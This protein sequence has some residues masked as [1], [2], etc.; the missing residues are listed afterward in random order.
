L[1]DRRALTPEIVNSLVSPDIGEKWIGDA[2]LQG[3]GVRLWAS[4]NGDGVRFAIR[5]RDDKGVVRRENFDPWADYFSREKMLAILRS[6]DQEFQWGIFLEDAQRWAKSRIRELKGRERDT[7]RRYR[8]RHQLSIALQSMTFEQMADRA[9]KRM[10]RRNRKDEYVD[11][12]RKLF[13]RLSEQNRNSRLMEIDPELLAIEITHPSLAVTQSRVLQAF[14]GQIYSVLYQYH[15]HAGAVSDAITKHISDIRSKQGVPHPVIN[16]ISDDDIDMFLK[17][18]RE[19]NQRWREA[20]AI[21]LYF[22]T[23]AK[24][25]RILNMMWCEVID[26]RWYP[27]APDKREY[28]FMGAE[29][30]SEEAQEV[31]LLA[32]SRLQNEGAVSAYVFPR[33]DP[34]VDQPIANIRRYW[35][36]VSKKM[37]WTDLPLSHVVRRHRVRNTPSITV[38]FLIEGAPFVRLP[39]AL[40]A[41]ATMR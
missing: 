38:A 12:V 16:N 37:G 10:E 27:Y 8:R 5:V 36:H 25:S 22:E 2:T 24:M 13:W 41:I 9:I 31:L 28:W 4:T 30:L 1:V 32:R 7:E 19:E 3:F 20:L 34:S 23:G 39:D 26:N 18:L 15:G 17:F 29:T 14:I 33:I 11:Q 21:H 40:V 6:G 35:R